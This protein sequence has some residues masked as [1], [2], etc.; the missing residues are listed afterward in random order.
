[1]LRYIITFL[2]KT[3]KAKSNNAYT[4]NYTFQFEKL[5]L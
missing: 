4:T 2:Y 3:T 1:M 5:G